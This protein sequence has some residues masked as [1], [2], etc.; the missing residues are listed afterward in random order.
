ML[1]LHAF[2]GS[3][4]PLSFIIR[5]SLAMLVVLGSSILGRRWSCLLGYLEVGGTFLETY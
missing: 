2:V 4:L 3:T 5:S 1:S